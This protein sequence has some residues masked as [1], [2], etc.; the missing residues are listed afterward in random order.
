MRQFFVFIHSW[1]GLAMTVFV[2]IVGLTGSALASRH[3][4][5]IWLNPELLTVS[6]RDALLLDGF[7]LREK[8]AALYPDASF[9]TI[10]LRIEPNR[11]VGF[12]HPP[13]MHAGRD[14]RMEKMVE[15]YLDPCTG[16]K[17]GGRNVWSSP[18][19]ERRNIIS[20]IYRLHFALAGPWSW[21]GSRSLGAYILGVTALVWTIDCFI[22]FYLTF[23]LRLR[24]KGDAI[25]PAKSWWSRW[26]SAWLI[27]LN[28]GGG[29][30]GAHTKSS[31]RAVRLAESSRIEST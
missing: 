9:D 5:D 14:N 21:S 10:Q 2:I 18:S 20:F 19:L 29:R 12:I 15:F 22:A 23:S 24:A 26:K 27:K 13:G 11:S 6:K 1:A 3:G 31:R 16:E 17:L 8:A 7:T 28:A 30:S 25:P 4:P